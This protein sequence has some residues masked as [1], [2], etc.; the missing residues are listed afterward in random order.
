VLNMYILMEYTGSQGL[1]LPS[2][3]QEYLEELRRLRGGS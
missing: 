2:D 3:V 1:S